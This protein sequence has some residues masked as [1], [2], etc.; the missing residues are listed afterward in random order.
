MDNAELK[1]KITELITKPHQLASVATI[2]DS[3]PWVRYMMVSGEPDLTL[4]AATFSRARKVEQ[5]YKDDHVHVIVGG[6]AQNFQKPFLNIQGTAQVLT[7]LEA[8]KKFWNDHLAQF[9]KGPEDP[10]FAVVKISPQV[11]EYMCGDALEPEVY[12]V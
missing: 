11:I 4:Y 9:F 7:D 12:E 6:D 2:K 5:L 8:K 3:R 1:K 10:D